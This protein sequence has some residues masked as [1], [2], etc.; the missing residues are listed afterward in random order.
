M[1]AK[2][3]PRIQEGP[4]WKALRHSGLLEMR[5]IRIGDRRTSLRLESEMWCALE[6][7]GAREKVTLPALCGHIEKTRLAGGSFTAALRAFLISYY[8]AQVKAAG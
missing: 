2:R 7:I 5:V 8:R 6:E 1:R 4:A 3:K